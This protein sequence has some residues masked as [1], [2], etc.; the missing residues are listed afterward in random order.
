ME[1]RY[2]LYQPISAPVRLDE[3]SWV[4][5][6]SLLWAQRELIKDWSKSIDQG[7]AAIAPWFSSAPTI[8]QP[9]FKS[10][11]HHQVFFQFVSLKMKWEKDENKRKRGRDCPFKTVL[12]SHCYY[13]H[14]GPGIDISPRL[15]LPGVVERESNHPGELVGDDHL[16]ADDSCVNGRPAAHVHWNWRQNVYAPNV[17]Q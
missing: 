10:Q 13:N 2:W 4:Q 17:Q 11:A 7:V 5:H 1:Y 3:V 6:V 8:L 12:I 15:L 16:T 14:I 9:G